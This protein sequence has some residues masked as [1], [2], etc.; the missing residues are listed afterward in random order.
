M[1]DQGFHF[2]GLCHIETHLFNIGIESVTDD[3]DGHA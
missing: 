1:E 3:F 2:S